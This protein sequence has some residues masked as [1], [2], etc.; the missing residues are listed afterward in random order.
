MTVKEVRKRIEELEDCRDD[1]I[2]MQ[3]YFLGHTA[4]AEESV[5]HVRAELEGG[6]NLMSPVRDLCLVVARILSDEVKRLEN[7]IDNA[8]VNIK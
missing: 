6:A 2:K 8:V 4:N 3:E 5:A 1:M 7:I